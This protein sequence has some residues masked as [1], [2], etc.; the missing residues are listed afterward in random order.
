MKL[1]TIMICLSVLVAFI[2]AVA[3]VNDKPIVGILT[4][5]IWFGLILI[6][7]TQKPDSAVSLKISL[8]DNHSVEIR[9]PDTPYGIITDID[10][11][12]NDDTIKNNYTVIQENDDQKFPCVVAYNND[13]KEL[14]VIYKISYSDEQKCLCLMPLYETNGKDIVKYTG[15]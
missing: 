15:E 6:Y 9:L 2:M 7:S 8:P 12:K 3:A 11:I 14:F 4:L 13:T 10:T 5:I 1:F